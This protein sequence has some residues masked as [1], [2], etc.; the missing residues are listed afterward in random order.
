MSEH[1]EGSSGS[2]VAGESSDVLVK[3]TR[4]SEEEMSWEA[5]SGFVGSPPVENIESSEYREGYYESSST[6][7]TSEITFWYRTFD[8]IGEFFNFVEEHG[9][10]VVK[11]DP[12]YPREHHPPM[13]F[14]IEIY[15]SYRG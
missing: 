3:I 5:D 1:E 9:K 11:P 15:D 2:R 7:G 8:S 6:D 12:T 13:D 4:T 10:V 14:E